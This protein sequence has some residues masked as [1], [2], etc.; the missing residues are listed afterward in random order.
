MLRPCQIP[1]APIQNSRRISV[2]EKVCVFQNRKLIKCCHLSKLEF[3][4]VAIV[5]KICLVEFTVF[6]LTE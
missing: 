1:D 2:F 3:G 5:G 6:G 4:I